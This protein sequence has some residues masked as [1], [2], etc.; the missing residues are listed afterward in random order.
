MWSKLLTS[1]NPTTVSC[2]DLRTL[3]SL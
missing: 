1:S 3:K 2:Q